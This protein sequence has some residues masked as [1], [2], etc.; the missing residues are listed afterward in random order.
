M[1]EGIFYLQSLI[2]FQIAEGIVSGVSTYRDETI[3]LGRQI[4]IYK[5]AQILAADLYTA[6]KEFKNENKKLLINEDKLTTFADYRVP[7]ILHHYEIMEYSENL[8]NK[9]HNK[10]E[11]EP[12]SVEEV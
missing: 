8:K 1:R 11:I 6:I 12:N 4:F 10:V 2:I 3:F 7:Q 9:I 5:R